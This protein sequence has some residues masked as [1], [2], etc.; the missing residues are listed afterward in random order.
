MHTKTQQILK[1]FEEINK[2]PRCSKHEEKLSIWLQEWSKSRGFEVKADALNNVL[3][4]VSATAGYESS[5]TL[6][7]QGHMDMVCEKSKESKHDFSRDPI[8]CIYDG[9]WLRGDGTSIGADNGIAL[10]IG[11]VLAEVGK[12]REIEHPP[13]ELLFTVDEETGLT[14]ASGLEA[15]FFE[16]KLLLNLDS[17]D[18][19]VFIAGCAGGQN[20]L[21]TLPV[22][23]E[24]FDYKKEGRSGFFRLSVE[25]L[26]GGHS[27]VE[28]HK[29]R[30]NGIQLLI[31]ALDELKKRIGT[32]S[33]RLLLISG[34][35][36]HNAI[37]RFA[38]ASV[39]LDKDKIGKAEEIVSE[40][41]K[42]FKAE[43]AKTD[44]ELVLNLKEVDIK[45]AS[46]TAEAKIARKEMLC[47]RI[48]SAGT[49][50]KLIG[51]LLGL[52]H[53]VYRMSDTIPGLVE[54]SNNLATVRTTENEVKILSSQRSLNMVRLAEIIGKVE[55]VAKLAGAQVKH[56][57]GYPSWE[58]DLE[59]GLLSKCRQVYTET[60]G[61]EPKVEIVH[62]GL[63][64]GIVGSKCTNME[65]ISLGPTIKDP[66][67]PAERIFIPSIEKLWIFLE[68]LLKSYH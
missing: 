10:A 25:G 1:V 49:E 21:I 48:F 62:A 53:G 8:K 30:A 63:E 60:F 44:P 27:G 3:I 26:E 14:G 37:P 5:P 13:L 45:A 2:I 7:L 57:P 29:Q 42:A 32:E 4:K 46:E 33:I 11:L 40:L 52:P 19:G 15:G 6:I 16:G 18:E 34:G 67:S 12:K 50:E 66:H 59:S 23:W 65:M 9:D 54:T 47:D 31:R 24:L 17:E 51:L 36:V 58:P 38:E 41:W 22:E 56:E 35:S 64:C 28:I 68:N 61:K 20:S 55:A 39:A 43:Y